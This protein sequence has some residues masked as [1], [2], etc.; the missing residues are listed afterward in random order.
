MLN[1]PKKMTDDQ[2]LNAVNNEFEES[3]GRP[4]TS[5]SVERAKAW[6]Y[7]LS[8]PFGDEEE[9]QSKVITSDVSDAVDG[10]MPSLL[11]L[12]TTAENLV[13]FEPTNK[14]DVKAAQQE[15]DYV[16]Y[17]FFKQNPAFLI[18]Y[19]WFMDALIQKNGIVKAMW[20]DDDQVEREEYEYLDDASFGI[21]MEDDELIMVEH[22]EIQDMQSVTLPGP[23]GVPVETMQPVTLHNAAFDRH[24]K[25]GQVEVV[26]V[27]PEE[28]RISRD[29]RSVDPN[30]ARMVGQE[31]E[32]TRTELIEMG[33]PKETVYELPATGG[34]RTSSY[35]RTARYEPDF[36]EMNDSP[37][38]ESEKKIL[39]REAY[40]RVDWDG[41]GVSQLRRVL[42]ADSKLL[43]NEPSDRQPFHVICPHP[44]PH[45]HFGRATSEKVMDIQRVTSTLLRQVLTNLYHTNNP[46]HAIW[47][48]GIG[49]DT[50]DDLLTTRIGRVARFARPVSEA[51]AP[52]TVP[53]TAAATFPMME[54]FDKVKRERTGVH[55]DAEGLS[56]ESLKNIQTTTMAQALDISRMKIE[57]IARIFAETGI[58]SLMLHIHELVQKHQDKEAMVELRNEWVEVDPREWKK[59]NSMTVKIGLGIGTRESNLLHLNAIKDFQQAI[60]SAGGMNLVVSPQNIYQTASEFVKNANLKNPEQFFTDPKDQQAP[61]PTDEEQEFEKEKQELE[62]QKTDIEQRRQQLDAERQKNAS[63]KIELQSMQTVIDAKQ[64]QTQAMLDQ[65]SEAEQNRLAMKKAEQHFVVEME[66][67]ATKLTEL[68]L[69]YSTDVEG[70]KV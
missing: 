56:P 50:L 16:N 10:I 24:K 40:I 12:F 59:R 66:K 9:G 27:P 22:S 54:Y 7:Y 64:K 60:V 61:P 55:A 14:E 49:E 37:Q 38:E 41:T 48:Q 1:N 53:F 2:I 19:I 67:I 30:E 69:K 23:D 46:G 34:S 32:V 26:N 17:V 63:D 57:A 47:E 4:D 13:G 21:L 65:A 42:T 39:V 51:Y 20:N 5:I 31:R 68:E 43:V 33:I 62:K 70:S 18:M 15:S 58:K 52:M 11:R 25:F 45:K 8:R 44:L 29:S 36:D 35:Q 28:Y 3:L 6:D